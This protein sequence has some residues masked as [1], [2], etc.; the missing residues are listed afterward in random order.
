MWKWGSC[1]RHHKRP[2]ACLGWPRW[3][4]R[5]VISLLRSLIK[6]PV[7]WFRPVVGVGIICGAFL[8]TNVLSG[9]VLHP[10]GWAEGGQDKQS[11]QPRQHLEKEEGRR[12]IWYLE[13]RNVKSVVKHPESVKILKQDW[14]DRI[15]RALS[16]SVDFM[17]SS[18]Q[19]VIKVIQT[20]WDKSAQNSLVFKKILN[21]ICFWNYLNTTALDL[22]CAVQNARNKY[23]RNGKLFAKDL[24]M[25]RTSWLL[26]VSQLMISVFR[27]TK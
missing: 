20:R 14:C 17:F 9:V 16:C 23:S 18:K 7:N 22:S 15:S 4:S 2:S 21:K 27:S 11:E 3:D 13:V 12:C 10:H 6:L 8:F 24:I 25:K 26:T 5:W 19:A 1:W